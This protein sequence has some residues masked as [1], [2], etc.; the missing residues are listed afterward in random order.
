MSDQYDAKKNCLKAMKLLGKNLSDKNVAVWPALSTVHCYGDVFNLTL[1]REHYATMVLKEHFF[2][3]Y[4]VKDIDSDWSFEKVC[5]FY[6]EPAMSDLANAITSVSEGIVIFAPTSPVPQDSGALS[7]V[8]TYKDISLRCIAQYQSGGGM[9]S[10]M[11]MTFEALFA[12]VDLNTQTIQV[13]KIP[14]IVC[15]RCNQHGE[16]NT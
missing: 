13:P 6:L 8:G 3:K 12:T 7:F 4:L 5:E 1:P 2:A 9:R 14:A 16:S 15:G 10:G 11:E